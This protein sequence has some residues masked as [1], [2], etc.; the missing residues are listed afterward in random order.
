M[1]N[2]VFC[3]QIKDESREGKKKNQN[4]SFFIIL[5]TGS[6]SNLF[7]IAWKVTAEAGI[8]KSTSHNQYLVDGQKDSQQVFQH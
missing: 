3:N 1:G 8:K 7:L 2:K 6:K 5:S 4:N